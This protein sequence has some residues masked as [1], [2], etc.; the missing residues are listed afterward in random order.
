MVGIPISVRNLLWL[1][2]ETLS[3]KNRAKTETVSIQLFPVDTDWIISIKTQLGLRLN[4]Q[5]GQTLSYWK[6]KGENVGN[7]N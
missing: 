5:K 4:W 7:G 1:W 3:L 2:L 6:G